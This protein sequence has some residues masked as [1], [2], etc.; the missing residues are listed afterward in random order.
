V[1]PPMR[2]DFHRCE[3]EAVHE[4][5]EKLAVAGSDHDLSW[6]ELAA[7][8]AR[9]EELFRRLAIPPGHPVLL[10]GHKEA[11]FPAAMLAAVRLGLPYVPIDVLVPPARVARIRQITGS[12]VAVH[13]CPND[14]ALDTP[15][16]IDGRLI[17]AQRLASISYDSANRFWFPDD[18]V[19]YIMFTSGSTASRRVCR[20]PAARSRAFWAGW[21]TT[22]ASSRPTGS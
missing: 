1:F 7:A 10:R 14:I 2:F 22:T 20:L 4:A 8:V 18:P 12:Q 16:A 21:S 15:I 11:H 3:F 5:P 6:A 17:E 13:L 9:F 19:F